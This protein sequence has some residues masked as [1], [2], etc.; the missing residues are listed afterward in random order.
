MRLWSEDRGDSRILLLLLSLLLLFFCR[1]WYSV[2]EQSRGIKS[3]VYACVWWSR[4]KKVG[5]V[6]SMYNHGPFSELFFPRTFHPL[7]FPNFTRLLSKAPH[8]AANLPRATYS[9]RTHTN[10][11]KRM[12]KKYAA[13]SQ[14]RLQLVVQQKK[15]QACR[16]VVKSHCAFFFYTTRIT[17]RSNRRP[18]A[19]FTITVLFTLIRHNEHPPRT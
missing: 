10:G 16:V 2:G 15:N 4:S 5:Y 11:P 3:S 8:C 13:S 19:P 17:C 6:K 14:H 1:Q 7:H 9:I 12:S 18:L